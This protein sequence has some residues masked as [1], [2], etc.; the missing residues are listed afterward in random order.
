MNIKAWAFVISLL[1]VWSSWGETVEHKTEEKAPEA[2]IEEPVEEA[3]EVPKEKDR[4]A[5]PNRWENIDSTRQ[6]G[7][8]EAKAHTW[9][10]KRIGCDGQE[11]P[12][13][14]NHEGIPIDAWLKLYKEARQEFPNNAFKRHQALK[15]KVE[16]YKKANPKS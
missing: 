5:P 11:I 16:A 14:G 6:N 13:K 7:E 1:I 12:Q 10:E 4:K 2:T 15:K 3:P 8:P 9:G